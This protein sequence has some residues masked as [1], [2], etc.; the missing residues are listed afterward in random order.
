MLAGYRN[1]LDT[2]KL[3]LMCRSFTDPIPPHFIGIVS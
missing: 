2:V 1:F 3:Y